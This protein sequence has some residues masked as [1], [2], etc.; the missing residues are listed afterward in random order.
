MTDIKEN[1]RFQVDSGASVNVITEK[2]IRSKILNETPSN[3]KM[4]NGRTIAPRG[5]FR[6]HLRNPTTQKKY[7]IEFVLWTRT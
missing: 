7:D 4:Y 3:L 6:L 5:K 2:Y 1:V